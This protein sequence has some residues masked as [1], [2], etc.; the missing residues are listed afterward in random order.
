MRSHTLRSEQ[1]V[2]DQWKRPTPVRP[3]QWD[4]RE[5]VLTMLGRSAP[6]VPLSD[7][8]FIT[9]DALR[10]DAEHPPTP[11]EV[12]ACAIAEWPEYKTQIIRHARAQ[13]INI[14]PPPAPCT[15]TDQFGN[16]REIPVVEP[17][18]NTEQRE[19]VAVEEPTDPDPTPTQLPSNGQSRSFQKTAPPPT[20]PSDPPVRSRNRVRPIDRFAP[21]NPATGE[22]YKHGDVYAGDDPA[23]LHWYWEN[24]YGWQDPATKQNGWNA[25]R[26]PTYDAGS[27]DGSNGDSSAIRRNPHARNPRGTPGNLVNVSGQI[28]QG[29]IAIT[30]GRNISEMWAYLFQRNETIRM[31]DRMDDAQIIEAMA[32]AFPA[33]AG[34]KRLTNLSQA[35]SDYNAGRLACQKRLV[36][37]PHLHSFRYLRT[38]SGTVARATPHGKILD[39]SPN[40]NLNTSTGTNPDANGPAPAI[41]PV[42]V[43]EESISAKRK[44]QSEAVKN[45]VSALP[46]HARR[47]K[48]EEA[49]KFRRD[50]PGLLPP[51][52][53]NLS[54]VV[55]RG[56]PKTSQTPQ[57]SIDEPT[58]TPIDEPTPIPD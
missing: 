4:A 51:A 42:D 17:V 38:A 56:R 55:H 34:R 28:V 31:F 1:D 13:G 36:P 40:P 48:A 2:I 3:V 45:P 52:H 26:H 37:A 29:E 12:C 9:S 23:L 49:R 7:N 46:P 22:P 21:T 54:K 11:G 30:E 24:G 6:Y 8:A 39:I 15:E 50:N 19:E 43:V 27:S 5:L 41:I 25:M 33:R 18:A 35:R 57:P 14:P 47:K 16:S 10:D 32:R 44:E 20:I 53:N 58:T